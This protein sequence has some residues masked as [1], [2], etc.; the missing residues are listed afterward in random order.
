MQKIIINKTHSYNLETDTKGDIFINGIKWESDILSIGTDKYHVL[1]NGMSFGVEVVRVNYS[2]KTMTLKINGKTL[3][4][5]IK[6]RHDLLLDKMGMK[7]SS[8]VKINDLKAPMPGLILD[9]C[10]SIGQSVNKGDKLVVLEA[11]KME[12]VIKASGSGI[13]KALK[14]KKGESVEKGHVLIEFE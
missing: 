7:K 8:A 3:E 14:A 9:V 12:N 4:I 1:R 13:V 11:M 2:D 10:V 6:D 5:D